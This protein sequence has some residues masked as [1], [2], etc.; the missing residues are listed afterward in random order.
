MGSRA[1]HCQHGAP[2]GPQSPRRRCPAALHGQPREAGHLPVTS[3]V[4]G[5]PDGAGRIDLQAASRAWLTSPRGAGGS[6]RSSS[7]HKASPQVAVPW[8]GAR[9]DRP[10]ASGWDPKPPAPPPVD[11]PAGT[12]PPTI[13][14]SRLPRLPRRGVG[15]RRPRW[16]C[17]FASRR[18]ASGRR[19]LRWRH[20]CRQFRRT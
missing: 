9:L 18:A 17:L 14:S 15:R 16:R 19:Q 6:G 12:G 8:A 10:P 4:S 1:G 2:P 3:S 11:S 20:R 5:P 13:A 7:G